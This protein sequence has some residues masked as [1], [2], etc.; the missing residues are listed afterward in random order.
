MLSMPEILIKR[1]LTKNLFHESGFVWEKLIGNTYRLVF[2]IIYLLLLLFLFWCFIVVVWFF[3]LGQFE[4]D[5]LQS[6]LFLWFY[7]VQLQVFFI[8]I[9][10]T[11]S[12]ELVGSKRTQSIDLAIVFLFRMLLVILFVCC[13]VIV[14][15][16]RFFDLLRFYIVSFDLSLFVWYLL[17]CI[18]KSIF[19]YLFKIIFFEYCSCFDLIFIKI[20]LII[21]SFQSLIHL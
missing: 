9:A 15:I 2:G 17:F 12:T 11:L 19:I 4:F 5:Q 21:Y 10:D 13:L 6:F 8:E 20:N 3:A 1:Y 18:I 16:Y 7:L 14:G